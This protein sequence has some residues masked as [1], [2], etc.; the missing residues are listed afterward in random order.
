MD[1]GINRMS[2][3]LLDLAMQHHQAGR[4]GE[5]EKVY[6]QILAQDPNDADALHLLGVLEFQTGR[7]SLSVQHISRAVE[8]DPEIAEFRYNLALALEGSG[9]TNLAIEALQKCLELRPDFSE[10]ANALALAL[11][12]QNRMEE[13]IVVLRHAVKI[14][15]DFAPAW[16]NLGSALWSIRKLDEAQAALERALLLKPDNAEA[17][18]NLG[19]VLE[20]K[21]LLD[22]SIASLRKAIELKPNY[23]EAYNN[24]AK[25]LQIKG[26]SDLAILAAEQALRLRPKYAEALGTLG[27]A[28]KDLGLVRDAI[29]SYQ[30]SLQINP[31]LLNIRSSLLL[32]LHYDSD[33]DPAEIFREHLKWNEKH[34]RNLPRE[35]HPFKNDPDR[36]RPLRIG[37]VSPDFCA[38]SVA[39]FFE[40]LLANHNPTQADVYCYADMIHPDAVTARLQKLSAHWRDITKLSN[41]EVADLIRADKIDILV[42]LAGHTAYNRLLV[43]ARKPAP[44][45]VSYLG[46]PNT[47]GLEAMD[48]RLTDAYA[49][50]IGAT[51]RFHSEKL[52]R[53]PRTFLCYRPTQD[54]PAVTP[55]PAL[56]GKPIIF[57]SLNILPKISPATI[58]LWSQVLSQIP[59]SRLILKSYLGLGI[60][61]VAKRLLDQF[62][63]A[64][65]SPDRIELHAKI[66]S[67]AAHL[68]LYDRIDIA[69]DTFPYHG[70]TTTCEALWMGVPV[71]T[72]AGNTHASR[73][74]VSILNNAGFPQ[75]VADSP[76]NF[77]QIA[78]TWANNLP[79]LAKIRAA[80]RPMM[81]KSPLLDAVQFARD[82]EAAYRTMCEK[83]S[84]A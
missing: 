71:I 83:Q 76:Q 54:M 39:Y 65:I 66:P 59:N 24:L 12:Q 38:H 4:A 75:F 16:N 25:S 48:Y 2:D 74:G 58:D 52:I 7:A 82:V 21:G 36:N 11:A 69:L 56:S 72:L 31:E 70:A 53:L 10:A 17:Y 62:A 30:Q 64:G 6:S 42:D 18:N 77:V 35:S 78:G 34:A 27:N 33:R 23:P 19:I 60:P 44:V 79:E 5:A 28:Q 14:K 15:P 32:A 57:G 63:A 20:A 13:A 73:V 41:T 67:R 68:S 51:E 45:Q 40:N 37:Y 22:A 3:S 81:A 43:F 9:E 46:Y 47:T 26:E 80:I 49:D 61:S 84:P 8:I 29:A 50:P 55:L 1:L